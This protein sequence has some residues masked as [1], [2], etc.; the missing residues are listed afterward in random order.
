MTDQPGTAL[1]VLAQIRAQA[2]AG[3]EALD[4]LNRAALGP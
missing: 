4:G 1:A 3:A 2:R